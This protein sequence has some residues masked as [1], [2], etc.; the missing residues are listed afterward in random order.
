MEKCRKTSC[1]IRNW[2]S[3]QL[4]VDVTLWIAGKMVN[5]KL[6]QLQKI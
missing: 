5:R 6:S 3:V 2:I 4:I 1:S